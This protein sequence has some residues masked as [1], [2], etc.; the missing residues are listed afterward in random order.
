MT[1]PICLR[2]PKGSETYLAL[3]RTGYQHPANRLFRLLRLG[4]FYDRH[5][6]SRV[7]SARTSKLERLYE[8]ELNEDFNT[9]QES[10]PT[11]AASVLDIG[12]GLAGIDLFLYRHYGGQVDLHLLDRDGISELY[13]GF[14]AE[15]AF[16]NSLSMAESLL[17]LNGVS[18]DRVTTYNVGQTDLP[19]SVRFDLIISL[20]SWG[21]HYPV[22]TYSDLVKKSLVAGGTVILDIRKG[23]GGREELSTILGT[24]PR[25]LESTSKFDRL[26]YKSA[27]GFSSA[28]MEL[29][30]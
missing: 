1:S 4:R 3:Q 27:P 19:D 9:I 12:C 16:Y 7:E 28:S 6:L 11:S 14:H 2:L 8:Q 13:Y 5:L 20:I 26:A 30:P 21:F 24:E 25:I 22:S 15:A 17:T 10:L 29:D 18:K 23:S